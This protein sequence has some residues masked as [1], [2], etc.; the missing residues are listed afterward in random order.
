M[1]L[2]NISGASILTIASTLAA[3]VEQCSMTSG[4]SKGASSPDQVV[5]ESYKH[6]LQGN[7]AMALSC[8]ARSVPEGL[9]QGTKARSVKDD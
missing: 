5:C 1:F 8:L 2:C 4:T 7:A 9:L 3:A 6:E